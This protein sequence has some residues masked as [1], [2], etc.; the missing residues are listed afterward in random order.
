MI[1]LKIL[2]C[3]L[4]SLLIFCKSSAQ[5]FER[6]EEFVLPKNAQNNMGMAVAD[7]D[8]DGYLDVFISTNGESTL[9]N[10]GSQLLRNTGHG[11][12][13]DATTDAGLNGTVAGMGASWGDYDNDGDPDI[14]FTGV[15]D[16]QL[17][18]NNG[19]GT[20]VDVTE[21]AGFGSG[22]DNCFNVFT[23]GLWWDYDYD[24]DLDIYV[25]SN[26]VKPTQYT[27][28]GDG[29]FTSTDLGYDTEKPFFSYC[30]LPLDFNNDGIL[31]IY[32]SNDFDL[33]NYLFINDKTTFTEAS[34]PYGLEDPYDG[35]GLAACDYDNDGLFDFMITN[36]SENSLYHNTGS[37]FENVALDLG[38]YDAGWAWGLVFS[39]FNLD[40]YEDLFVVN[41]SEDG[42]ANKV[43]INTETD[44][45][46]GFN[47]VS[48]HF[49]LDEDPDSQ[50][51]VSFDYD[52]DGDLDV[53]ISN[54]F[55]QP[56]FLLNNMDKQSVRTYLQVVLEGTTSNR[57]AV[58]AVVQVETEE[59][60]QFRLN[61]GINYLSQS[62]MPLHFGLDSVTEV[63]NLSVTW[64]TGVKE[65]YPNIPVNSL[66]K[67]TE[68]E[69]F[70]VLSNNPAVKTL[71]CTDQNSCNYNP[72]ATYD[73]GSCE[74]LQSG[75]IS[76][77]ELVFP[78]SEHTY[79]YAD[80]NNITS[81]A[82]SV[83]HGEI[84]DGQGTA[85]VMVRWSVAEEGELS[86]IA[87]DANCV[88]QT[89]S[90]PVDFELN[91]QFNV[92]NET[93]HSVARLWNEV[94]LEAIRNDFARPTVHA[95]NLFHTSIAMYDS[96]AI[97][98][99]KE[100]YL[101]G[102]SHHAFS[103]DFSG[104]ES[105]EEY[106]ES[107]S[108]TLSYAMYAL[109]K[110]RFE[111][112]PGADETMEIMNDMMELL[113]YST[114]FA[115]IDYSSGEPAAMGNFIA[116]EIIRYGKMD[117]ANEEGGYEN[118]YYEPKNDPLNPNN[119]GNQSLSD[120]NHWQPLLLDIFIDQSG[121]V[122]RDNAPGFLG[123]E[124]GEV[125][126]FSLQEDDRDVY[127]RDGTDYYVYH[128]PG[129]PPY[130]DAANPTT[131]EQ[132]KWGFETVAIWASHLSPDDGVMWDIS[133]R[134]IGNISLDELP[135]DIADYE[136]FYDQLNGGDI[137]QGRDLNPITGEPY[138]E[139]IVPRGDYTRV[140]AEFW[141]DGPDSETPPGH[142]FTILNYV[143]DQPDLIK[144]INGEG[145]ELDDLEWDVKTYFTLGGAMHDAA[146][147]AWGV[148][149]WYDYI[150]PISA[151][152]YLADLGQSTNASLDNYN[153]LGIELVDGFIEVVEAG[154]P[155]AG[156]NDE[157]VGKIKLYTWR[158]HDFIN[159]PA[160][161]EA[162]VGW[163]LA[164]DWWPYQ[165]PS[166]ITPPFAG[167]VSG[168]STFS[169]AA[170]EV[171]TL[172]T[173]S[174]YFPGG[175][176]TF[177]AKKNEFLVFED[178][179]SMDIELEW[180]TYRD[181]SDQCS[182][183]RI[184]GG[185]HP[186]ADDI[187]GR[188]MGYEIGVEAFA[189]AK[190]LFDQDV[191]SVN[192]LQQSIQAYPNPIDDNELFHLSGLSANKEFQLLGLDGVKIAISRPA[193]DSSTKEYLFDFS[194]LPA[195]LY[196]LQSDDDSW[197]VLRM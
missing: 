27:N 130:L 161:D 8:L 5:L 186:P 77:A 78:L 119:D 3:T 17:Y 168:H 170:A 120:P 179:P 83:V 36:I 81:Y 180:A 194:D 124:W 109:M 122:L 110:H 45:G 84:I 11:D 26:L 190:A 174:E 107:V 12:F 189:A 16:I 60:S 135:T 151:T 101:L 87:R 187:P 20:F 89:I 117:G 116:A 7:Y 177:V 46:R 193:Y 160:T 97:H 98:N 92:L 133:P 131:S 121:N 44:T 88:T 42:H 147:A 29:T 165:R 50:V 141:A 196:I 125:Y 108:E 32:V 4:I 159:V 181:A 64:P 39:D 185:I 192:A 100:T 34:T 49:D 164:E 13:E 149:G 93:K 178:G 113:G 19:D 58:G 152:R 163:I 172:L 76:G 171:M 73:D 140:L 126:P 35:M 114:A 53:I 105:T 9:G 162:G 21:A 38:V 144:K 48:N 96:W 41:Q 67:L 99:Q 65:T 156:S 2:F 137:G 31:D 85:N 68:G 148:K 134:S 14:F 79:S 63:Q 52:N 56:H 138:K 15:S 72:E 175:M 82:W 30:A 24:G 10:T 104:F 94:M 62:Q 74:Y 155:L 6:A 153:E 150:R 127:Q 166:F 191:L 57:N 182:L 188:I 118:L 176:G 111:E 23:G 54:R 37:G 80:D 22:C 66:I 1:R 157:N 61:Q 129:S 69:G 128:N 47:D 132:Y 158:G 146:I 139:Q 33:D 103:S 59:G 25:T 143:N 75:V 86:L 91:T 183:S 142:W 70:E 169:R 173:G 123:P 90:F 102:K 112:S 195:G 28:N 167:F 184:W 18:Q 95:R 43:Y 154:D 40:G 145:E 51:V 115:S 136:N 197:K 71:G 106:E 55:S